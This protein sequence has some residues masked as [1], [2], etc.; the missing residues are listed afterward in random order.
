MKHYEFLKYIA[1]QKN[2]RKIS[3]SLNL[4]RLRHFQEIEISDSI[5]FTEMICNI[6]LLFPS[7]I[8]V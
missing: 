4:I 5:D 8:N 6:F 3:F 1:L 7:N 2:K